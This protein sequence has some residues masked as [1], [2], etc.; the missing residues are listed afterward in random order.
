VYSQ[1]AVRSTPAKLAGVL[2]GLP[3]SFAA[4]GTRCVFTAHGTKHACHASLPLPVGEA[5]DGDSEGARVSLYGSSMAQCYLRCSILLGLLF[6]TLT[7][8]GCA[9]LSKPVATSQ[10]SLISKGMSE[11]EVIQRLGPPGMIAEQPRL[12]VRVPTPNGVEFREKRRYTYYY[13]GTSQSIDMLIT[14]E[15]GVVVK[16]KATR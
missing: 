3:G 14:F 4:C 12:P 8:T 11:G 5:W 10:L 6:G 15:D 13:P 2:S 9:L 1:F 16:V 7:L